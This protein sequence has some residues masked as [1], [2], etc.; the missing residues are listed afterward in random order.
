VLGNTIEKL[1]PLPSYPLGPF[2][3]G[4]VLGG[5]YRILRPLASGGMSEVF[6]AS[7]ERLPSHFAVKAL[8]H[9]LVGDEA[10][11]SRF[12]REAEIMSS[13]RHPNIVQV[14]DFNVAPNGIPYLVMEYL[15][16]RDL[17]E[18]LGPGQRMEPAE[19]VAIVRQVAEALDAAHRRGVVHRD[20]KPENIVLVPGTGDQQMVKVIDFGISKMRR[21]KR[22]TAN[23]TLLGTPQF[24]APEQAQ[25]RRDEVDA[26]TDEFAL[27]GLAYLM[28]TGQPPFPDD[29]PASV[30]YRIVH[31]DPEP[32]AKHVDWP[33]ARIEAVL[34]TGMAKRREDRYASVLEFAQALATAVDPA[35]AAP[36]AGAQPSA[37]T[38]RKLIKLFPVAVA[39]TDI[40]T[41]KTVCLR[42]SV[43]KRLW[44]GAAVAA[45]ALAFGA[46]TWSQIGGSGWAR[47]ATA[48]VG[49]AVAQAFR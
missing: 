37:R 34:R 38:P 22:I 20:L 36:A 4:M 25:G 29:D 14:F 33:C 32:M 24:M 7:H 17:S 35:Q 39:E 19:V 45:A 1:E 16:G 2:G 18:C 26:R 23:A 5:T 46:V 13:L 8:H 40:R 30:L 9:E 49:A 44:R 3:S 11:M 27:A 31:H 42:E 21:A 48:G 41:R 6:L 28:M 43:G 10:A 15:E 47:G 12:R